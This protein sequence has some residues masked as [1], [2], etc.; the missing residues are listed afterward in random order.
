MEDRM[1]WFKGKI[2][3][4]NRATI[5]VLAPTSQYGLNVFEGIRGY[6]NSDKNQMY[7][8]YICL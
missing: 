7:I 3:P 8:F 5:N 4:L 6:W 1:I 2:V